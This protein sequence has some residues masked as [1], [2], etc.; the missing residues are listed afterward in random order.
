MP[1]RPLYPLLTLIL[2]ASIAI[3]A[4]TTRATAQVMTGID[5]VVAQD[6][7]MFEGKRVGLVMNQS[8]A[9]NNGREGTTLDAFLSSHL[10]KV[11]ALFAPEHGIDGKTPAG[12][13][14]DN[15]IEPKTGLVV[16]SLYGVTKKPTPAM[17]SGIDVL[18]YDIQDIGVRSYTFI[19][20][21]IKV[22]E[23]CADAGVPL[24]VLDR[25]NPIGGDVIDG[26][27]LDTAFRSFVG[28]IP[29]PYIHGMTSGELAAMA[30]REGWLADG[31][32]CDLTVIRM[33]GW[34]RSMTWKETGLRWAPTSPNVQSYESAFCNGITGAIGDLR[35]VNIGIGGPLAFQ[36]VSR[37]WIDQEVLASWMNDQRIPGL[38][39]EPVTL[40]PKAESS[41]APPLRGIRIVRDGERTLPFTAQ[42]AVLTALRDNYGNRC[43]FDSLPPDRWRM[44]DK[45]CGTSRIRELFLRG[46]SWREISES[47]ANEL[48]EFIAQRENYLLY[49]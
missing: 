5:L 39:F 37:E 22:M 47:W 40:Q 23:G 10:C 20:T 4:P 18:V 16:H 32:K 49:E 3:L 19:S 42:I 11:V 48:R 9:L 27:V 36:I 12:D 26:P 38:T 21:L 2:S 25:P 1:L 28:I 14:V 8:A 44:F 41:S 46:E 30:N 31:A 29:I 7:S 45:V 15:V 17:L 35:V 6:F 34:R 24:V 33:L 43:S 13:R